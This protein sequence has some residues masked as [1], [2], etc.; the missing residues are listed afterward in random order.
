M[1]SFGKTL[2]TFFEERLSN[3]LISSF[4]IA[5]SL[6]NYKVFV[7]LF[8]KNT[9]TETFLLIH[10]R[11]PDLSAVVVHGFLLPAVFAGLYLFVLPF[12]TKWVYKWVREKQK[13]IDDIRD[14][15]ES[16]KR[17]TKEQSSEIR[18][19]MREQEGVIDDLR[20]NN[21]QLLEDL[22]Q[23]HRNTEAS[24][25][26]AQSEKLGRESA[27][28]K[29]EALKVVALAGRN[30]DISGPDTSESEGGKDDQ[31]TKSPADMV[32]EIRARL[33]EA[34]GASDR[35]SLTSLRDKVTGAK[36]FFD[37]ALQDLVDQ[38]EVIQSSNHS[39]TVYWIT[40]RGRGQLLANSNVNM[41]T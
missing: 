32:Q 31:P 18:R 28:Q 3:P 40:Q 33:L 19:N 23:A 17:L 26:E 24:R 37:F 38:G 36:V 35:I 1:E 39:G 34:I 11:F 6:Y 20:K 2:G 13:G 5:W 21:A 27:E 4:V 30:Q 15:Y 25:L 7:I 14:E 29:L 10:Q 41:P 22:K 16:Q 8:S 9:V 12:P